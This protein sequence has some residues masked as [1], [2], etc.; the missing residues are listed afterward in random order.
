[1]QFRSQRPEIRI[2][3]IL[4]LSGTTMGT[5]RI[6]GINMQKVKAVKRKKGVQGIILEIKKRENQH[7]APNR[8]PQ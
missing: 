5:C 4:R 2:D 1:M 6:Q 7:I 8:Y 3:L